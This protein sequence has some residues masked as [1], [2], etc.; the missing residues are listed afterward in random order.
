MAVYRSNPKGCRDLLRISSLLL[1]DDALGH[2]LRSAF[3]PSF[4]G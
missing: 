1:L 4:G 3:A 2:R